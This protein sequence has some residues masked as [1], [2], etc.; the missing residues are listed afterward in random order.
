MVLDYSFCY[1]SFI[2]WNALQSSLIIVEFRIRFISQ[3]E[4]EEKK[5]GTYSTK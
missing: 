2:R 5:H 3:T 4:Q 1:N